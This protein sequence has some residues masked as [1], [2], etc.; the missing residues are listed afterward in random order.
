[1]FKLFRTIGTIVLRG[2]SQ[3]GGSLAS[4]LGRMSKAMDLK[5][6]KLAHYGIEMMQSGFAYDIEALDN[7]SK[8]FNMMPGDPITRGLFINTK[9]SRPRNYLYNVLVYYKNPITGMQWEAPRSLWFDEPMDPD[10]I[11]DYVIKTQPFD[12]SDP[13]EVSIGSK[14]TRAYHNKN[15]AWND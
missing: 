14:V 8:W 13:D 2:M 4:T 10:D 11:E 9:L 1:M 5:A 6:A 15:H 12:F 3:L 7:E